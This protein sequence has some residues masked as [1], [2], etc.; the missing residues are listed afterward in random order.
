MVKLFVYKFL[1][2]VVF[3]GNIWVFGEVMGYEYCGYVVFV[4]KK[5]IVNE[6]FYWVG[7]VG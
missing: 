1:G 2:M 5:M 7:G 4:F 3:V 6:F